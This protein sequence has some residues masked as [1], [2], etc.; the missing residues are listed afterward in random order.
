M[1]QSCKHL[2]TVITNCAE[3]S[4][5]IKLIS[6]DRQMFQGLLIYVLRDSVAVY[7]V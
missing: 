3:N 6:L 2:T 7:N 1:L 5:A 4:K